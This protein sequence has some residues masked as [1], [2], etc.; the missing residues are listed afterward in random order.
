MI[1]GLNAHAVHHGGV[2]GFLRGF[3]AFLPVV[4]SAEE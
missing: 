1:A 4:N 3:Q 2:F